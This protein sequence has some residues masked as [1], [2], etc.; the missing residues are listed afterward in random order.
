MVKTC[1]P[2]VHSPCTTH[3][4]YTWTLLGFAPLL[5]SVLVLYPAGLATIL[6]CIITTFLAQI[7][8]N[9]RLNLNIWDFSAVITGLTIAFLLPLECPPWVC[10]LA[11]LVAIF[12]A[13][14]LFGGL[15]KNWV[16]PACAGTALLLLF[17]SPWGSA[18]SKAQGQFLWGYFGGGLAELS[19]LFVLIGAGILVW[20]RLARWQI[21]LPYLVGTGVTALFLQASPVAILLWG[22]TIFGAFFLASD[23]VTSPV[24]RRWHSLYGLFGGIFATSFAYFLPALGGVSLGIICTNLLGRLADFI[25]SET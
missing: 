19:T 4:I 16:N 21:Y 9:Y 6:V 2:F 22:G 18:L 7:W 13:K 17:P 3:S 20:K 5:A 10:I 23:P 1:A 12:G 15:G 14:T 24:D 11:S 25:S 8:I